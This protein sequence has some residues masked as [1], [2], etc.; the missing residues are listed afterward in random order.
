MK[1]DKVKREIWLLVPFC[2]T[3]KLFQDGQYN[4]DQYEIFF[5]GHNEQGEPIYRIM[6]WV[7]EELMPNEEEIEGSDES[8]QSI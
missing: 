4:P 6:T 7:L 2:T 3:N 5:E 8:V 1:C